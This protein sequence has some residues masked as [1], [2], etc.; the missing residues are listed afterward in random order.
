MGESVWALVGALTG[1][2]IAGGMAIAGVQLRLRREERWAR[3]AR[4]DEHSSYIRER[5]REVYSAFIGAA[6]EAET[7]LALTDDAGEHVPLSTIEVSDLQARVVHAQGLMMLFGSASA[8]RAS[9]RSM[10]EIIGALRGVTGPDGA[11]DGLGRLV[12]IAREEFIGDEPS[13]VSN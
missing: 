8:V 11:G 5:R 1:A 7:R 12:A 4:H 3:Q 6:L 2:L 10:G 9:S 13:D